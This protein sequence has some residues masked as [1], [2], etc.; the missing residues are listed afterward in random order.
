MGFKLLVCKAHLSLFMA[1][2]KVLATAVGGG[3][4]THGNT[5]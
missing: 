3:Q 2:C 5:A 1:D 4:D